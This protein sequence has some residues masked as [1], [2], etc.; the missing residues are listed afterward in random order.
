MGFKMS[1]FIPQPTQ[2]AAT[3][4]YFEKKLYICVLVSITFKN[5]NHHD[6]LI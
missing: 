3:E 1:R 5:P 2:N 4:Q 6:K